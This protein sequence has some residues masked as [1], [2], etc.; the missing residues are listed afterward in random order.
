ML[1]LPAKALFKFTPALMSAG[2]VGPHSAAAGRIIEGRIYRLS[3]MGPQFGGISSMKSKP[4]VGNASGQAMPG[5]QRALVFLQR[6]KGIKPSLRSTL[7]CRGEQEPGTLKSTCMRTTERW[8]Q[9]VIDSLI[10]R[11]SK[12]NELLK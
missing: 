5:L 9:Q 8:Y 11:V 6:A 3:P 2:A 4:Q 12:I 1:F 7:P 10:H